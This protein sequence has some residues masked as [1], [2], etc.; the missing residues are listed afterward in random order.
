MDVNILTNNKREGKNT[1]PPESKEKS[2]NAPG[3]ITENKYEKKPAHSD[4]EEGLP[5][6]ENMQ[7]DRRAITKIKPVQK[8]ANNASISPAKQ[9]SLTS[10]YT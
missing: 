5:L 10:F 7:V 4:L 3:A 2:D 9:L 1:T 6:F 8:K